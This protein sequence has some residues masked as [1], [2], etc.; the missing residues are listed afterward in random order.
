MPSP[1][2]LAVI[3]ETLDASAAAW[4]GQRAKVVWCAHDR[5]DELARLLP[6]AAALVVRTYTQVNEDLLARAPQLKVVGRAGVGLDNIDL[7]ACRRRGVTVVYTPD[8][9]TR[10]VVEYVLGLI[11]DAVRPR[12]SMAADGVAVPPEVFHELRRRHVG[13]ELNGL[14]LGILGLGRIGRRLGAAAHALG[15]NLLVNDLLP[16]SELRR[17]VDYPF[18]FV[19]K[20]ALYAG[21]DILSIHV[22]GRPENRGLLGAA[23]LGQLRPTCLL[24]N[25]ARG[26]LVDNAALAAWAR[27]VADRGGRVV[28]DVHEPEPPP[29]D[30][31]LYGLANVRLL[32]HLASRTDRALRNMSWVVRDVAAVLAG[33]APTYP[34][35]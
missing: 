28:L 13:I 6:D 31:P 17:A 33:T 23:A 21:S 7:P 11:L 19:D 3:T 16:E 8:A 12:V 4:L 32:P 20:P 26:M 5:A 14:T 34:A 29:A 18:T 15:M 2:P 9:N 10:A 24:I 22:D 25:A 30:Y 35:P 27:A 1:L